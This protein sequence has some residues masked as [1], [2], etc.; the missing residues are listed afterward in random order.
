MRGMSWT[1]DDVPAMVPE[2]NRIDWLQYV[3]RLSVWARPGNRAWAQLQELTGIDGDFT[4]GQDD[5]EWMEP[6]YK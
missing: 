2:E 1:L 6:K 3:R 5:G 4:P